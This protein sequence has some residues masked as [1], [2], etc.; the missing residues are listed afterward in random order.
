MRCFE[1]AISLVGLILIVFPVSVI[2]FPLYMFC[3]GKPIFKCR[4]VGQFNES[5]ILYKFRSMHIGTPVVSSNSLINPKY[6]MLPFG[7]F[8]RH[9]SIDELPQLW[10]VVRGELSLVG[11]RPCLRSQYFLIEERRRRGIDI[12]R[13][14]I[15]GYA[16]V[17]GRDKI[18]LEEK[19]RLDMYFL[20]NQSTQLYF[21]ILFRTVRVWLVGSNVSH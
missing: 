20:N 10:N 16:Q 17:N 11:P 2:L 12:L 21:R 4:R 18:S 7:A 6:F 9:F 15:T 3:G 13:P 14:G 5:F 8:L 19:I 1:I